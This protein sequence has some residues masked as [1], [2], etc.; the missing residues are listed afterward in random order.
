VKVVTISDGEEISISD[1]G[2]GI[3]IIRSGD[4]ML[5]FTKK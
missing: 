5:R 1:L 4:T 3:Y 2:S